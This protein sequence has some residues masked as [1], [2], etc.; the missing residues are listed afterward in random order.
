M[1]NEITYSYLS[2]T[3]M[4]TYHY[5]NRGFISPIR[6]GLPAYSLVNGYKLKSTPEWNNFPHIFC[7]KVLAPHEKCSLYGQVCFCLPISITIINSG[8]LYSIIFDLVFLFINT[9]NLFTLIVQFFFWKGKKSASVKELL[10]VFMLNAC[11]SAS[12]R[13]II[14]LFGYAFSLFFP[15]RHFPFRHL[16]IEWIIH[17][18]VCFCHEQ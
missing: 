7:A 9:W 4:G 18:F 15:S 17:F 14:F 12:K 5:R 3:C 11:Q 16:L 8:C 2:R 1:H 6:H 13:F 10:F